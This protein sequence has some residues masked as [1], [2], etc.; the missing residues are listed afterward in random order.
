MAI[1]K[2]M[3]G[4]GVDHIEKG[5]SDFDSWSKLMVDD[6]GPKVRPFLRDIM[7]WSIVLT[8]NKAEKSHQKTNCWDF[9]RCGRE[10]EGA[11]AKELGICPAYLE[12]NLDGIHEGKNGG[13]ACWIVDRTKCG[14]RIKRTFVPKF[15]ICRLCDFRKSVI[16]EESKNF[17]VSDD[18]MKMLIR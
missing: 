15:I 5:V 17:I 13:R 2:E 14:G 10:A 9:Q 8:C 3:L 4:S 11:R 16:H 7:E 18:F 6:L 1:F 12:I